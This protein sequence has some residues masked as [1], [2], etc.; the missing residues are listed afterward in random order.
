MDRIGKAHRSWNMSRIRST[1]TRP[2]RTVRS[3]LHRLGARFRKN[4]GNKLPGKPDVVLPARR[5]AIFVHGCFWHR[6]RGCSYSYT[7]K[8]RLKF[9]TT[10]FAGNVVRDEIV[11][12]QL[13]KGGWHVTVVWECETKAR[14][15]L[16]AKLNRQIRAHPPQ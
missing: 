12:K 6:H 15:R 11:R 1:D 4:T 9:W 13:R 2:E 16:E 5:M 8:S 10:K 7:P 14:K 3:L